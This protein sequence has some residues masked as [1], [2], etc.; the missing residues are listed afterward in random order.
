[1]TPFVESYN[2]VREH[3][4]YLR[5]AFLGGRY[6]SMPSA[7]TLSAVQW[8]YIAIDES[9]NRVARSASAISYLKA[10]DGESE[11]QYLTRAG[12]SVYVN[13]VSPVVKAY[14]EGVTSAVARSLAGIASYVDDVDRKGTPWG[15][16]AESV[17]TWAAVYGMVATVVDA[18]STSVEGMSEAERAQRGIAPYLVMVHPPA[19]AWIECDDTGR[20]LEFAYVD[21]AYQ[22]NTTST[23]QTR[24]QITLRVWIASRIENG[25]MVPGRW[26]ARTGSVST[27]SSIADQRSSFVATESGPLDPRLNGEIPVT[28]AFYE[29]DSASVSPMGISLIADTADASRLIYNS[30]SWCSE[31]HRKAG[32]PFL[33]IPLASTGGQLDQ[34]T[35]IKVGPAQGLGFN[36]SSGAPQWISPSPE[37]T[38]ELREH[39]VFIFQ[40][41]MRSAGLEMAADQ[42]AQ[43]Q[44]GEALRIR[45]RDF[46]SR[47]QRFA[48]NMQ[49]WEVKTLRLF[50][51]MGGLSQEAIDS[52]TISYPKRITMADPSEELQRAMILISA[53]V[54]IGPVAKMHAIKQ[55]INAALSLSDEELAEV[56]QQIS[57]IFGTD[58]QTA[59]IKQAVD[60]A[61]A[62][63]ELKGFDETDVAGDNPMPVPASTASDAAAIDVSKVAD[64][65]LNGAQMASI[66]EVCASVAQGLLPK[67]SAKAIIQAGFPTFNSAI[68]S[69]IVDPIEVRAPT[70]KPVMS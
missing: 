40:W 46:E 29:R 3:W 43:T 26:E 39:C 36:A 55:A 62:Q 12:L 32:F 9:N 28:F 13:I 49:R 54:E 45:S 56:V 37:S 7:T 15:E 67:E 27:T 60:A 52:L 47:A 61:R 24:Q 18:P 48:R 8:N 6:W 64:T 10:H 34:S 5:D 58:L 69:A 70:D 11:Q 2:L 30:L 35:A 68:V 1:M 51:L 59:N 19:F 16:Y 22:Q 66:V 14:A 44:S 33:A 65:A 23:I 63:R 17:A 20:L 50:G 31:I 41:A 57:N 38:A 21:H 53:P 4:R 25:T 42:S